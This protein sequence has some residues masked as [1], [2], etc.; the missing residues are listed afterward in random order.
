M[1][2]RVRYWRD[3]D[4]TVIVGN[5]LNARPN[6]LSRRQSQLI[7]LLVQGLKND[8]IAAALGIC[9]G[10]VKAYLTTLFEKVGTKERFELALFEISAACMKEWLTAMFA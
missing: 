8:E 7:G 2:S 5:L 3:L 6:N 1:P 10:T 9:E 4:G